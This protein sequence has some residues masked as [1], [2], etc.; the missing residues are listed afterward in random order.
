M[1]VNVTLLFL[2]QF[3][4]SALIMFRYEDPLVFLDFFAL[5]ACTLMQF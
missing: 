5:W 3:K 2:R 4:A 1:A